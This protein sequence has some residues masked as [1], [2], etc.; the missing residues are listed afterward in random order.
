MKDCLGGQ[1]AL[2]RVAVLYGPATFLVEPLPRLVRRCCLAA[3]QA[4][5][6]ASGED[7]LLL[8]SHWWY[9]LSGR[10]VKAHHKGNNTKYG[11]EPFSLRA[12]CAFVV[13]SAA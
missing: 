1:V 13:Y 3:R 12:L 8:R 7:L 10:C 11:H 6:L 9:A 4:A 2:K 5:L